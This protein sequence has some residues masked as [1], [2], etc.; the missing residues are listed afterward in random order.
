M[1]MNASL[2]R[3][4]AQSRAA[5]REILDKVAHAMRGDGPARS[6]RTGASIGDFPEC[7]TGAS[8]HPAG[9]EQEGSNDVLPASTTIVARAHPIGKRKPRLAGQADVAGGGFPLG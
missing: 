8:L 6:R 5:M 4:T 3:V 1:L 9:L 7:L 2:Y